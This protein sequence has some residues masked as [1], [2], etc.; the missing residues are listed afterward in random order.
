MDQDAIPQPGRHD[1]V[2]QPLT[3]KDAGYGFFFDQNMCNG[4]KACQ[5]ACK[6]KHDLPVGMNWRRVIEYT[7]GTWSINEQDGT[8]T[9]NVFSYYTSI[10]CNHCENP[11]CM[12]VCPTTAMSRRDDG[13][14]YVDQ[15]KCVGC[16]YCQWACPYGAPQLDSRTGHMSKC[17]LCYDY[18]EQGQNPACVDACPTRALGWGPIEALRKEFGSESGIAPLPDPS[19]T[20]PHLVI[21]PH[22]DAQKWDEGTGMIQ[23]PEEI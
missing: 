20:K 22:R 9:P 14:V 4:C 21:K 8:F 18:R 15:S 12:R 13:T 23:N 2:D 3:Q 11:I 5:I 16:R 10:S 19:I 7:G 1:T 17:D 6:D